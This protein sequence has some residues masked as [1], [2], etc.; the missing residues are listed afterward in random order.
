MLSVFPDLLAFGLFAPFL[1]RATLGLVFISFGKF[2]LG[3]GRT[4]KTA[5]FESL[6]WKPGSYVAAT[7][8]IIEIAVGVLLLIGLYTQIAALVAA[9]ISLG[10]LILKRKTT[11]GIESSSGF[12]TLLCIISLSLLV[13]GAG[14]FAF[15]FPL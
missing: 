4:E 14:F 3:R 12:L 7:L 6:G 9:I 15:D 1:L 8:G 5:F 10:A 13:S 11:N 2:K